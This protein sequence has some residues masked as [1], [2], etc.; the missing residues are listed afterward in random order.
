MKL[1]LAGV[2]IVTSSGDHGVA[3]NGNQC[4][5]YAGCSG[6]YLNA[7]GSSGIF[8]PSFPGTCPYITSVGATQIVPGASVTAPEEACETVIYSGGGFSNNFAIPS[9][10]TTEVGKYFKS[11][12][13]SYSTTL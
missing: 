13:P 1:G 8:N 5:T 10:Q 3:G 9:Y 7:A 2:T 6:G 11:H 4:C 12:K